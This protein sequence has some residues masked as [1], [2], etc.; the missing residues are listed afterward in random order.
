MPSDSEFGV[1]ARPSS[2]L[3][4]LA[5]RDQLADDITL[6]VESAHVWDWFF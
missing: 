4:S 2:I 6:R 5:H 1:V 3:V